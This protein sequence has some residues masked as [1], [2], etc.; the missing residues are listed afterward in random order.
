[1]QPNNQPDNWQQ[2]NQQPSQAPYVAVPG[3]P[4]T[5]FVAPVVTLQPDDDQME[6]V[7]GDQIE[8]DQPSDEPD[9]Q[10]IIEPVHWQAV[11]YIQRDKTP[12]WFVAFSLVF[13]AIMAVA[14]FVIR[15]ITFDILVPVMA[16]ALLVYVNRPPRILNYTLSRQGL[17][18]NDVLY[19]FAEFKSFG[20]I[21]SDEYSIILVPFKRFKPGV[22]VYFPEEVGESLVDMLGSRLPMQELKLDLVDQI[23]RKL[24]I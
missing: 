2:P 18:I 4:R 10:T 1:M 5:E 6:I 19:P 17:H 21:K 16:V 24:R 14:I 23:I 12:I 22:T 3:E 11:E 7:P 20:V 13:I 15:S 8:I 9:G